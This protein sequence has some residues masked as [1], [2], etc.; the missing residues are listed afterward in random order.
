MRIDPKQFI[1]GVPVLR[2]RD[3][4]KSSGDRLTSPYV[5]HRLSLSQ[6]KARALV[7][8]LARK[9][10]IEADRDAG[11]GAYRL[12]V[13]GRAFAYARATRPLPR[14]KAEEILARFLER[15]RE[16]ADRNELTH[17]VVEVRLFGSFLDKTAVTLG[18]VDLAVKLEIRPVF[19]RDIASYLDERAQTGARRKMGFFERAT[20]G[21][22]EVWRILKGRSPFISF[23]TLDDLK[24]LN[25]RFVVVYRA[26]DKAR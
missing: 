8:V 21:E 7:G 25:A 16:V 14:A 9:G 12:T 10:W 22:R 3:L 15:V 17:R 11:R 19:G 23:H 24:A 1:A 2:V 6:T 20:Y 5:A 13:Q 26:E 4:F 18:D